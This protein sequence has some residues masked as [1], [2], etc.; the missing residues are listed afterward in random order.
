MN[1]L[2]QIP[3]TASRQK[4]AHCTIASGTNRP[5]TRAASRVWARRRVKLASGESLYNYFRDYDPSTGRYVQ[6][7]PIGLEGGINTYAYVSGNPLGSVDPQGLQVAQGARI[8][9]RIGAG[10]GTLVA[11][12][13]GTVAGAAIGAAIGA[14]IGLGIQQICKD[15]NKPCPPCKLVDG[16][17]VPVGTIGYRPMDTP[18]PGKVEHGIS[19]PHFNLYKANQNPNNCQC[20]WQPIGAAPPPL[21]PNWIPIQPFAN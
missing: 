1:S 21:Q 19:G 3:K 20:F 10:I 14:G 5:E 9:A 7:D 18:P 11:P 2:L 17:T 15:D 13:G 6:S 12:G 16:T 8:G 4:L